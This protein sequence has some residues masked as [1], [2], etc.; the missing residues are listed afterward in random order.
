VAA[1]NT[2]LV[3][4]FKVTGHYMY[5]DNGKVIHLYT[6]LHSTTLIDHTPVTNRTVTFK[7]QVM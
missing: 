7:V 2:N 6:E 4:K 3:S 5:L 1:N